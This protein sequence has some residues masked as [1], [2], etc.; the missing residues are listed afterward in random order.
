[1]GGIPQHRDLVERR[2]A[3]ISKMEIQQVPHSTF[4]YV[5]DDG[6]YSFSL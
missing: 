4:G 6:G 1:M 2:F 3:P 5:Q